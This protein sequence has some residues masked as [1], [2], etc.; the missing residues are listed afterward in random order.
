M[1][2]QP[3]GGQE[4]E[5]PQLIKDYFARR[6]LDPGKKI[7]PYTKATL[8]KLTPDQL[9]ALDAVG[10]SLEKDGADFPMYR[11]VIH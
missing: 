4:P 10:A 9:K 7:P 2:E 5:L 1:P 11:F 3:E 6:G 8:A